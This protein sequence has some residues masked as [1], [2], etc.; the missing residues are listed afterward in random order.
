M[1]KKGAQDIVNNTAAS[2][3]EKRNAQ[4]ILDSIDDEINEIKDI[5]DRSISL[6]DLIKTDNCIKSPIYKK[7]RELYTNPAGCDSANQHFEETRDANPIMW[8]EVDDNASD[9]LVQT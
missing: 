8:Y 7:F 4:R 2:N 6:E 1:R 9:L 5:L 3:R